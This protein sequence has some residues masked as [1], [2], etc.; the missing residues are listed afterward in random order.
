M[1]GNHAWSGSWDEGQTAGPA[2]VHGVALL[3]VARPAVY[4]VAGLSLT[5]RPVFVV[6]QLQE[7][8]MNHDE[9]VIISLRW[10]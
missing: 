5:T 3:R 8:R 9:A 2:E 10:D 4:R 1:R 7:S 6:L